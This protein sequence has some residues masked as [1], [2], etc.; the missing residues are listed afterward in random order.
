[1]SKVNIAIA[2]AIM[3]VA[4]E[5]AGEFEAGERSNSIRLDDLIEVLGRIAEQIDPEGAMREMG[6]DGHPDP[7]A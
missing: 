7:D 3:N 4:T 2:K 5:L 6:L 1:M